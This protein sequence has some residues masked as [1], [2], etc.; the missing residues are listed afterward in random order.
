MARYFLGQKALFGY[1]FMP[2]TGQFIPLPEVNWNIKRTLI[3]LRSEV[4]EVQSKKALYEL[5]FPSDGKRHYHITKTLSC[6]WDK[7][8]RI[9]LEIR[10]QL[11]HRIVQ[12]AQLHGVS[13]VK[14]EDLSW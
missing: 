7:I 13:V 3:H 14:F 6:L 2:E 12:I 9:H 4:R 8:Q 1:A 5:R 11:T 10:N